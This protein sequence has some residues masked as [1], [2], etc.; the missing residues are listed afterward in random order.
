VIHTSKQTDEKLEVSGARLKAT[1]ESFH[2]LECWLLHGAVGMTS[3]WRSLASALAGHGISSRAVD[4]WRFLECESVSMPDF[5]KRLNADAEG[6]VSRGRKR[7]LIAYS[8]GGRLALHSLLEGGPWEA[9]VI[10]SADPGLREEAAAAARRT[11]D[12]LWATQALTMPWADFLQKWNSQPI[13]GSP[14]RDEREE[15]KLIQRR[16][17][18]ARSFVDWSLGSQLPLWDGLPR[19]EIPILWIA[20]ER[21]E[22]FTAL[23]REAAAATGENAR[24][25]IAP[26]CGHRIPWEDEAWLTGQIL[27]FT[28]SLP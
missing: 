16:R 26:G 7:V 4:L 1:D 14:V 23:A 15:K 17:E 21:D 13:L 3:D 10:I 5:G 6:E 18:I 27:E 22:K 28:S 9:A 25:A 24:L 11:Q 20:G 12:T 19:I 2:A 8:M